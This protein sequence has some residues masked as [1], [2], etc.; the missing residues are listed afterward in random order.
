MAMRR[1][2]IKFLVPPPRATETPGRFVVLSPYR[3]WFPLTRAAAAGLFRI[4]EENMDESVREVFALSLFLSQ[5]SR[6]FPPLGYNP[7]PICLSTFPP[8]YHVLA[9]GIYLIAL[10]RLPSPSLSRP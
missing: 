8:P 10:G 5:T 3:H 9:L 7:F 4:D 1:F 2:L 6:F